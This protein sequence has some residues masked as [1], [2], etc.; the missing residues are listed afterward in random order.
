MMYV[1]SIKDS[2]ANYYSSPWY[3]RTDGEAIR[4]FTEHA[5]DKNTQVG[6]NPDDFV[7]FRIGKFDPNEGTLSGN[8]NSSDSTVKIIAANQVLK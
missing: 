4:A 7:L 6:K 3:A 8:I 5:N 1:Y 2:Q